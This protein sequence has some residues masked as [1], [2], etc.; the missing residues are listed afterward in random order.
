MSQQSLNL[1]FIGITFL[2]YI[3]IAIRSRATSTREYYLAGGSVSPLANG[4]ATG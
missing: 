1:L 3:V 2:L 4:M